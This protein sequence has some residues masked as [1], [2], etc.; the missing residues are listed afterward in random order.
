MACFYSAPLAWDPTGVDNQANLTFS[1]Q[2]AISGDPISVYRHLRAAAAAPYCALVHT[3]KAWVLSL[4]PELFFSLERGHLTARP[5]KGTAARGASAVADDAAAAALAADP[6]NRAEN[7]MIV[8]LLRNDF[9]RIAVPGSV[10]VPALFTVER[11]PT[12]LQMTSTITAT[13]AASPVD[14]IRAIFPCG[15]ITG[16]PKIRAME[17]IASIENAPRGLYTGSI[18]FIS[19]TDAAFNVAIRTLTLTGS[20]LAQIGLGA[21]IVADS[22]AADEWRECLAKGAF[23]RRRPPP[24]LIETMRCDDGVILLLERHLARLAAT[25]DYLGYCIDLARIRREVLAGP[26]GS[27]ERVRLLVSPDG[28]VAIKRAPLPASVL[29]PIVVVVPLPVDPSDWRLRHKTADRGFYDDTRI[30]SQAFEVLFARPD[31]RLTEGS[32]TNIF[33]QREGVLLTPPLTD[34]LLPG[35]LRAELI[36]TGRAIEASLTPADLT[37]GFSIGNAVRGL[38]S[39]RLR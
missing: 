4:S 36:A 17:V 32:F 10:A 20:G 6:K 34:G 9:A 39:A 3:G 37:E 31:G 25:A 1:A 13:T 21:G 7:L 23:L 18:G 11:Y 12:L 22:I 38:M 27:T 29:D 8:D 2:V 16:A 33:V 35:V 30:A 15:S 26:A 14:V 24:D 5:M 19:G 28:A